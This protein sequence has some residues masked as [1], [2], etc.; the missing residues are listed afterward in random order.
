MGASGHGQEKCSPVH[1]FGDE[2]DASDSHQSPPSHLL[3]QPAPGRLLP[4]LVQA[5]RVP[6]DLSPGRTRSALIALLQ[7]PER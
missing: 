5:E 1:S 6:Y 7:P 3:P 2:A 4:C